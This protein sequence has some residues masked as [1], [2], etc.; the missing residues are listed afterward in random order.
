[1]NQVNLSKLSII[2]DTRLKFIKLNKDK[3]DDYDYD[4]E[5]DD[6]EE[7]EEEEDFEIIEPIEPKKT[8]V[9]KIK[10]TNREQGYE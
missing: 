6:E 3:I 7:E 9:I 2:L 5:D 1:M 8:S 4:D 10:H